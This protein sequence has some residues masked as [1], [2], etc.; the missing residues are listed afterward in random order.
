[1]RYSIV[2]LCMAGVLSAC[3]Y[4][5]AEPV[6]GLGAT[7]YTHG[8]V[9]LT[10]KKGVTTQADVLEVFGAPN[11]ATTDSSGQELWTYQKYAQVSR[12][13]SSS[14][15]FAWTIFLLGGGSRRA[16]AEAGT[17]SRTL[18]LLIRFDKRG[19]VDDFKSR[20]SS[21]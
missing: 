21:F 18:T 20:A 11:V 7:P 2:V 4:R 9:Q 5:E 13:S 17:S 3:V 12:A 14:E 16:N 10:L 19:I 1:M 6:G 15:G 8:Q